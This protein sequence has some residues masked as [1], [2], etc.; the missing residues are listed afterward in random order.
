VNKNSKKPPPKAEQVV[1]HRN[2]LL[3]QT[4]AFKTEL[5]HLAGGG[6]DQKAAAEG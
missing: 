4:A 5:P 2:D 3:N 6:G 1:D